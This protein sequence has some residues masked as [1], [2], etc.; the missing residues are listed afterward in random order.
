[1]G[2]SKATTT[3]SEE[4][5]AEVVAMMSGIPVTRIAGERERQLRRMKE[6]MIDA[7]RSARTTPWPK[8]VKP[9]SNRAPVSQPPH[10]SV[11][12]P[13]PPPAWSKRSSPGARALPF[14]TDEGP[15][16]H[17]RASTWRSSP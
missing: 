1:M 11:H 10:R 2:E 7:R 8:V 17:R 16:C 14:D 13:G 6:E 15:R 4:N 9:S 12:L 3:V 5:V